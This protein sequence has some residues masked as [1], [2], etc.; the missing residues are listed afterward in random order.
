MYSV[1][2]FILFSLEHTSTSPGSCPPALTTD[3]NL[4][5]TLKSS[6]TPTTSLQSG[7]I[8]VLHHLHRHLCDYLCDTSFSFSLAPQSYSAA[9]D[10]LYTSLS[11]PSKQTYFIYLSFFLRLKTYCYSPI[12]NSL[13]NQ[14]STTVS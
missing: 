12:V 8:H 6:I 11:T 7:F 9:S 10:L 3:H 4:T 1:P 2:T 14:A 5:H 13:L